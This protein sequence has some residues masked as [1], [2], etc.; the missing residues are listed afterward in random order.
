MRFDSTESYVTETTLPLGIPFS[1]DDPEYCHKIFQLLMDVKIIIF[2]QAFPYIICNKSFLL[3]QD[4][5]QA[6]LHPPHAVLF[7]QDQYSD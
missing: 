7:F 6:A 5:N 1:L 3:N 4:K 2:N